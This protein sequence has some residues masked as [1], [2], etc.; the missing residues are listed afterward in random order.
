MEVARPSKLNVHYIMAENNGSLV[1]DSDHSDYS[2]DAKV[3]AMFGVNQYA[4]LKAAATVI[5]FGAIITDA[6]PTESAT[7]KASLFPT[8]CGK[9]GVKRTI[10]MD[11]AEDNINLDDRT[12][13]MQVLQLIARI[14]STLL[15]SSFLVKVI[16]KN[17]RP[18]CNLSSS[19]NGVNQRMEDRTTREAATKHCTSCKGTKLATEFPPELKRASPVG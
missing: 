18:I 14:T 16:G 5:N 6:A 1:W 17:P 2:D 3:V 10:E 7:E 11:A 9:G 12:T 8:F 15:S 4:T 19:N 13:P